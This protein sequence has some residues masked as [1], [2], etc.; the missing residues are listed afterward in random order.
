M[1]SENRFYSVE[2]NT[3]GTDT[4]T[5][6]TQQCI[7]TVHTNAVG[8]VGAVVV[9]ADHTV[10]ADRAVLDLRGA[11]DVADRA[12]PPPGFCLGIGLP[13]LLVRGGKMQVT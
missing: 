4:S 3:V 7:Y 6:Y 11:Q 5:S 10:L 2:N 8:G 9:E 13:W 1:H 12:V